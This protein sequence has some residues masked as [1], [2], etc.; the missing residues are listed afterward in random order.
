MVQQKENANADENNGTDRSLLPTT[1]RI[2]GDFAKLLGFSGA[3][4]VESQQKNKPASSSP[5]VVSALA[6]RSLLTPPIMAA[7]TTM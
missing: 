7:K 5:S 3:Y 6:L 4:R 2:N 1:Q